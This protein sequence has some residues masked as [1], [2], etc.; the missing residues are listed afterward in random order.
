MS[1][2]I[3]LVSHMGRWVTDYWIIA[4]GDWCCLQM[5]HLSLLKKMTPGHISDDISMAL[6]TS[7]TFW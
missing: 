2:R 4:G 6:T 7:L 3:I 5:Q 1:F